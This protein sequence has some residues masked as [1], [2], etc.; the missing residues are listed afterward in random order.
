[1]RVQIGSYWKKADKKKACERARVS[2]QINQPI[3]IR[4]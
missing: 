4:L 1:M 2:R 3:G